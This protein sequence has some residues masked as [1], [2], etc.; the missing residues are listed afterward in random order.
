MKRKGRVGVTGSRTR[1]RWA[2]KERA[3][4]ERAVVRIRMARRA[5]KEY[6]PFRWTVEE[7]DGEGRT[8]GV[9]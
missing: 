5:M 8:E 1:A 9:G 3:E 6:P 7:M 2:P 4:R